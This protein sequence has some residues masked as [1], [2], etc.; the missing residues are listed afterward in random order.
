MNEAAKIAEQ[1]RQA[2]SSL[3]PGF[4]RFWGVWLGRPYDTS[5]AVHHYDA[6]QEILN[7]YFNQGEKLSIWS[8]HGAKIT[9]NLFQITEAERVRWEWFYY[10]RPHLDANRFFYDFIKTGDKVE[11]STNVNSFTPDLRTNLSLPA[12]EI[13]YGPIL[14]PGHKP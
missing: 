8:P 13:L 6:S 2:F 4:P 10:G 3:K 9:S 12:F 1:I 11:A 7:L 14:V 5:H